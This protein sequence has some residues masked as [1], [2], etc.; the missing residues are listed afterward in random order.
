MSNHLAGDGKAPP[1]PPAPPLPPQRQG[2]VANALARVAQPFGYGSSL[3]NPTGHRPIDL[4]DSPMSMHRSAR[5]AS[6]SLLRSLFIL[7]KVPQVPQ[8]SQETNTDIELSQRSSRGS[9]HKT[10]IPIAALDIS[11]DHT[12]AVLAGHNILKTIQVSDGYCAEDVN[13]RTSTIAYA[14]THETSGTA[15]AAKHKGQWRV[16]DVKWSHGQYSSTIATA[17]AGGQIVVYD[18]NRSGIEIARLHEHSRQVHKLGINPYK[19]QLI[20]SG[21]QDGTVRLWD[22]RDLAGDKSIMTCQSRR[23]FSGNSEGIRDIKWSPADGMEFALGTDNGVIQRWDFRNDKIPLLR[24]SAHETKSCYSIDWHPD[25]KHIASGGADKKIKVWDFSSSDRRKKHIW[26]IRA[27]QAIHNVRW[28]P[29]RWSSDKQGPSR[30]QCTQMASSYDEEDPRIH[31]WDFRQPYV[32]F[33]TLDRYDTPATALLWHSEDRLWSV[34]TAGMFTQ[35]IIS[36]VPKKMDYRNPNTLDIAADGQILYFSQKRERRRT[37]VREDWHEQEHSRSN[38]GERLAGS[39]PVQSSSE[40]PSL[41]NSSFKTRNRQQSASLRPTR[42]STGTPPPATFTGPVASLDRSL[43]VSNMHHFAQ[44]AA[45]GYIEGLL[46]EGTPFTYLAR[47]YKIPVV[48][49]EDIECDLHLILGDALRVNAEHAAQMAKYRLSQSWLIL[50]EVTEKELGRRAECGYQQRLLTTSAQQSTKQEDRLSA[51]D[52]MGASSNNPCTP[53]LPQDHE[54]QRGNEIASNMTTPLARPIPDRFAEVGLT[55]SNIDPLPLSYGQWSKRPIKAMA[56]TSELANMNISENVEKGHYHLPAEQDDAQPSPKD[57]SQPLQDVIRP[58]PDA[59]YI[60]MDRQMA[61]R[62]A[63][64]GNYRATPRPLLRLDDPIQL[65]GPGS[66]IPAFDRHDSN[67]S[68]QLFPTST[69]SSHHE[70]SIMG[71]F[72]SKSVSQR[73]PST[74][75]R[76]NLVEAS[77]SYDTTETGGSALLFDDEAQLRSPSLSLTPPFEAHDTTRKHVNAKPAYLSTIYRP[78]SPEKP[79]VH[80]E[81]WE[82]STSPAEPLIEN[83]EAEPS[84]A[85]HKYLLSDFIPLGERPDNER[86]WSASYLVEQLIDYH[87]HKLYDAQVPTYLLLHLSRWLYHS[88]SYERAL[89]IVSHYHRQLIDHELY[90]EAAELRQLAYPDFPEIAEYGTYGITPGGPFCT[91]CH[92]ARKGDRRDICERCHRPCGDCPI[93]QNQG[94]I[95]RP[96]SN[97]VS[98]ILEGPTAMKAIWTWCQACGHGGH[99]QCLSVWWELEESEG[100]CPTVGC[101]CDCMPGARRD[102]VIRKLEKKREETK[103]GV[104]PTDEWK[105]PNVAAP[106]RARGLTGGGAPRTFSNDGGRGPLGLAAA[107]RSGSGGKRVRIV[108]PDEASKDAAVEESSDVKGKASTP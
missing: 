77:K 1:P 40:E 24:I 2:F 54:G 9:S 72:G 6:G 102:E 75:E 36:E 74:P 99:V 104:I 87:T 12:H 14:A 107:G 3:S 16:N 22:L 100:A 18:I 11:P 20:L 83:T 58:S 50:A 43:R 103:P 30:W 67:E 47:H 29:P 82:D 93:C 10:G 96:D 95:S 13:L 55:P 79:V 86:P 52:E 97:G 89:S 78:S 48:P 98:Q 68:F 71:S 108:V 53:V 61:E 15:I 65:T 76:V 59:G 92:K 32:P 41:S 73:I 27:P 90:V 7:L 63:A 34:G 38:T 28:R 94:P 57:S 21:S 45:I 46:E 42:S 23:T 84:S 37:D 101:L 39:S 35:T 5:W 64:M 25:G 105:A 19:G 85:S 88:I 69:D 80:K 4:R 91:T 8:G 70:P 81:D 60:D 33:R 106:Q 17:A 26:E 51:S 56:A 66:S 31:I 49:T 44:V 62:R